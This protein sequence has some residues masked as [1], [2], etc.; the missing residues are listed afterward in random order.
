M[1][2]ESICPTPFGMRAS[3][4]EALCHERPGLRDIGQT[5][6]YSQRPRVID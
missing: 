1:N 6:M 5:A 2:V 4:A 3:V